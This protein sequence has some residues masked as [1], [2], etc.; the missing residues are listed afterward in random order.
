[1]DNILKIG[2]S[3]YSFDDW[4]GV[5]YP[6]GI[7]KGKMLDYYCKFFDTVEINSTYY[8]IPNRSVFYHLSKKTPENFEFIVKLHQETTHKRE[9]GIK[10]VDDVKEGVMPILES[11]K[12]KGF[13]AQ[14]PWSFKN[15]PDAKDYLIMIKDRC[16]EIPFFVEFRN[17]EWIQEETYKFFKKN[18]IGYCCVDE[19]KLKGL[20]PPQDIST[21][22]I[23]YV[24]FHGRNAQSWW[25]SS[26]GDRYD[27]LYKE[28]ELKEW[29]ERIKNLGK[30]TSKTYLFF[31]NCHQGNAVKN[32]KMFIEMIKNQM[33]ITE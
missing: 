30:N 29:L 6:E 2:T 20:I 27:Y 18:Q 23:G 15:T 11:G 22:N 21:T 4:I 5:F 17:A 33:V 25:D 7:Q 32:A 9:E 12:L 10:A 1:L 3:G 19:P 16:D 8:K 24:R 26:K 14:F 31:N 28:E 13:L